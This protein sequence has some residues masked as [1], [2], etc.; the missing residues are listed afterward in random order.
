MLSMDRDDLGLR[1]IND[2]ISVNVV[3]TKK[4]E[5]LKLIPQPLLLAREGE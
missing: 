2:R 5:C 4:S 3:F 1:Q